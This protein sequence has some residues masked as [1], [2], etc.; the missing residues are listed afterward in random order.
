M[1]YQILEYDNFRKFVIAQVAETDEGLATAQRLPVSLN[2]I[3][4][5]SDFEK[6]LYL[7]WQLSIPKEIPRTF[8]DNLLDHITANTST[9]A[10]IAFSIVII[11]E[12]EMQDVA[13]EPGATESGEQTDVEVI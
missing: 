8:D 11:P 9:T 2:G 4:S 3:N 13:P 12:N 7:T 6:Q 1:K 5:V 10:T